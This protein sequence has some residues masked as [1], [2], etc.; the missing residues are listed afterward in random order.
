MEFDWLLDRWT[1]GGV[2][3][4]F[5]EWKREMG[6]PSAFV[7]PAGIFRTFATVEEIVA[8]RASQNTTEAQLSIASP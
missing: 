8:V 3:R 1:G 7:V 5:E 6:N 4:A 2:D